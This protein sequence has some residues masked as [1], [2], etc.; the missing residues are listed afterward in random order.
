MNDPTPAP[1]SEAEFLEQAL[2]ALPVCAAHCRCSDRWHLLWAGLKATGLLRGLHAQREFLVELIRRH[3]VETPQVL[4]AGAA[5]AASLELLHHALGDAQPRF[6]LADPCLAPLELARR[7]AAA[8]G[9]ALS[10]EALPLDAVRAAAPWDLVFIHYTLAFIDAAGRARCFTRLRADLSSRGVLVCAVRERTP[11]PA[12]DREQQLAGWTRATAASLERS[13][14]ARPA[15]LAALLEAL[16][17]YA[18]SRQ[19]REDTMPSFAQV[20]AELAA[21]GF[22]PRESHRNPG[23][24]PARSSDLSPPGSITNWVGVFAPL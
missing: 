9:I 24:P 5:D 16:P 3:R 19:Q 17:A 8:A 7:H 22:A 6:H 11:L 4:I 14:A 1:S 15:L 18:R 21:A 13:F 2:R 10:C 12:L 20:S 23:Q